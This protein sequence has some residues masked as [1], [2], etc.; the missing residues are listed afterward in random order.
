MNRPAKTR[1]WPLVGAA[2]ACGFVM[3][4]AAFVPALATRPSAWVEGPD[5]LW[6]GRADGMA[7]SGRGRLFLAPRVTPLGNDGDLV[8]PAHVWATAVDANGNVYLGTGPDGRILKIDRTGTRS[9]MFTAPQPMVTALALAPDG[10]LLAGTAP[11]G[12]VY[13][14]D[15][16]GNGVPWSETEER[17]VW[18]LVVGDDGRIFAGTGE[19]GR[20]LEIHRSGSTEVVF[21]S[22]ESHIVSLQALP[23]GGLLAGGAGRG[24]VFRI[25][26]EGHALVLHEDDLPEVVGLESEPDGSVVAAFV[27][28]PVPESRRPALRLRLPDGVG[29]GV[30]D[31]NVGMLEESTGPVL[32]GTIEGLPEKTTAKPT[33]L[34]GRI[35]RIRPDGTIRELWSSSEEAPLCV[36]HD[37]RGRVLFGTGEP[38]R[39]YRIDPRTDDVALLTTLR[40]T[41]L[42]GLVSTGATTLLATSNPAATYRLE[43]RTVESGVFIS[44]SF[45][46]GGPARWGAIRWSVES[47]SGRT[48]VYTRTGNSR[49]PDG[50]W[51]AWGPA[52]SD[53]ARSTVDNPDG[54]FI[55]WRV[56]QVGGQDPIVRVHGVTVQ[57]EPYN[58]PPAIRQFRVEPAGGWVSGPA[59]FRWSVKDPD[60]DPVEVLLQYRTAGTLDWRTA[61]QRGEDEPVDPDPPEE[62]WREARWAWETAALDEGEYELRAV[63]TDRAAN[64]YG[65]GFDQEADAVVRVVVDRTPP[66]IEILP[67]EGKAV[68]IRVADVHSDLRALELVREGRVQFTV[69]A[70]DG[71]CDSPRESFRFE[72]PDGAEG[73]AVRGAD[74]AGNTAERPLSVPTEPK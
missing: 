37:D 39:L 20:V 19:R 1:E 53:P 6:Q 27:A 35:V 43:E 58:R 2:V 21:D 49:D 50:T 16:L 8:D 25:D 69:R 26:S 74:A 72:P 10:D 62:G 45:D 36:T 56:R 29:V 73:W 60:G 61:G 32:R 5:G 46:A 64:A 15:P 68:R 9:V 33:P 24:L 67:P 7:V 42:T 51:S 34:R 66:E 71:V 12:T 28:P 59:T 70:E 14:I 3:A 22:D 41:H 48:E 30:T 38:A 17:Y 47:P 40:E 23:D 54:R 55:Q 13:R 18:S 4:L 57:Y 63:A 52:L 44:R 11:G 65:E 31:E